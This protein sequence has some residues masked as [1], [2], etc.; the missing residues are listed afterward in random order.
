MLAADCQVDFFFSSS[1]ISLFF[2]HRVHFPEFCRL[3][4]KNAHFVFSAAAPLS[5][6]SA[7]KVRMVTVFF[8]VVKTE[9]FFSLW[10]GVSPVS[11]WFFLSY[12]YCATLMSAFV[13]GAGGYIS[14]CSL[15]SLSLLFC[16]FL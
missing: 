14:T 16:F 12:L 6:R 15:L 3:C 7:P 2:Y 4:D 1:F 8:N 11:L 10:K 9:S 13:I 5:A